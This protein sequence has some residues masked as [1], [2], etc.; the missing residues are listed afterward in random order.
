[1]TPA[2][3]T[4]EEVLEGY[5]RWVEGLGDD[6]KDDYWFLRE[7]GPGERVFPTSPR[8]V[9]VDAAAGQ[10]VVEDTLHFRSYTRLPTGQMGW[11]ET[12]VPGIFTLERRSSGEWRL[13]GMISQTPMPTLPPPT[14]NPNAPTPRVY[15]YEDAKAA[16]WRVYEHINKWR[17]VNSLPPLAYEWGWQE[18]ANKIAAVL[19]EKDVGSFRW[20]A[21]ASP[22]LASYGISPSY[23]HG[24]VRLPL[25]PDRD[26]VDHMDIYRGAYTTNPLTT[27][28]H[29][30]RMAVGFVG[31]YQGPLGP[32][33]T[34][35]IIGGN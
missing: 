11:A 5:L 18:A 29:Y 16:A 3:L 23:W 19:T 9:R 1:P 12:N 26:G 32:S 17:Q 28:A 2:P 21:D 27:R 24:M 8:V 6:D 25:I 4:A 33:I 20:D 30:T 7:L 31:P 14:R 22:I 10:G 13:L 35:V 15:T 34:V